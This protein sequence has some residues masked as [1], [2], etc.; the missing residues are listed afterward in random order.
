MISPA[1][2]STMA[3]SAD[4]FGDRQW[5]FQKHGIKGARE[6]KDG[7]SSG[8]DKVTSWERGIV[9]FGRSDRS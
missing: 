2:R 9:W 8:C 6:G 3:A 5:L 1:G 4:W 7:R